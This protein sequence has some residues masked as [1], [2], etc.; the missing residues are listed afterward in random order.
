MKITYK[1]N[2]LFCSL[3]ENPA[4]NTVANPANNP[5]AGALLEY[6]MH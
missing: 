3:E 6:Y 4:N 2:L 1:K 5:V